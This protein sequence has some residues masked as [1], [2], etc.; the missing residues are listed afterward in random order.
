MRVS[1][2]F[3][4][5][6]TFG[7]ARDPII[8]PAGGGGID[9]LV[10]ITVSPAS[11]TLIIDGTTPAT[12]AYTSLGTFKDGHTADVTDQVSWTL[13]D[14]GLGSF[15][16]ALFTSTT[17]HGGYTNVLASAGDVVGKATLILQLKQRYKDPGSTGLPADPGGALGG[18]SNPALAAQLVY[19]NDGVL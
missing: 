11:Q 18:A 12:S 16:G 4:A 1:L 15:T 6:V 3:L 5:V 19:P 7:C 10:S 8:D 2:L 9:G 13:M 14:I 17:D